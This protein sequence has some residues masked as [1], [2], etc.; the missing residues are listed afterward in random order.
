MNVFT[1]PLL[2]RKSVTT[3]PQQ[4][5]VGLNF[6]IYFI[7]KNVLIKRFIHL[8]APMTPSLPR[9]ETFMEK[10]GSLKRFMGSRPLPQIPDGNKSQQCNNIQSIHF[11]KILVSMIIF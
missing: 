5:T 2:G 11:I 6:V 7:H 9:K 1:T 3:T 4:P 10:M 8:K